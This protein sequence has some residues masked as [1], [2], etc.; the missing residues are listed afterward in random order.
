MAAR[1]GEGQSVR[2][3]PGA[4]ARVSEL[5]SRHERSLMRIAQHWSLCRDDALDA[6]Q[7]A[8]EI[9]LR[10]LDS[11]D[12]ATEIAW[13]KVV[14][15][16]EALA[17][18]RARIDSVPVEA[19]DFDGRAAEAQRPVDDLLAGRERVRRSA[20][21]L[22]RIKPDEAKALML[23]A[24]GLSYQE[25]GES[26]SW[27]YTKVNRAITEGRARFLKVYA[28]IEAGEECERFA[29]TLAALVGGTASADALLQ[30][31]PHIRN[32]ATCRATVR[33]LHATRL[34]RLRALW[35][36]PALLAS[37]K[38]HAAGAYSRVLD[39]TPLAGVRP[40]AAVAAV[41]GCLAVGGGT[42]YCVSQGV[43]PVGGLARIVSPASRPAA[44]APSERAEP[45]R[46]KREVKQEVAVSAPAPTPFATPSPPQPS[47]A[48]DRSSHCLSRRR[49][50]R[51]RRSRLTSTSRWRRPRRP[52]P[53]RN[54][55]RM[56]ARPRRRRR[57]DRGSSTDH[58]RERPKGDS[59][60]ASLT[61]ASSEAPPS[62]S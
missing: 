24:Q 60:C 30:L 26:L 27:T 29:P 18:R 38:Q 51:R 16:H 34:G 54:R 14:V 35:P 55:R 15:K 2:S 45:A 11:L 43:D 20:E 12:P 25:I 52:A 37:V 5:V 53:R 57:A 42:T 59:R 48:A 13:L 10:R 3:G 6:Y 17:V 7:R 22:R 46:K 49:S 23:K 32:C 44:P 56:S 61:D 21:A 9:Y 50:R 31:R 40:G 58:E 33:E 36:V 4:E 28:E 19:V 47:P 8:L 1:A 39:P 62:R 41:A